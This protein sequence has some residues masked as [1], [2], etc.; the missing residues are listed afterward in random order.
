MKGKKKIEDLTLS[1]CRKICNKVDYCGE[2]DC[3]L[4]GTSKCICFN[5]KKLEEEV[6]VVE[7]ED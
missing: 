7:D 1:Q 4:F 3:P 6:E 2:D 5:D